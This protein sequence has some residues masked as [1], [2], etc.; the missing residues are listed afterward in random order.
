[1]GDLDEHMK[2]TSYQ[3]RYFAESKTWGAAQAQC[4]SFGGNLA[5]IQNSGDNDRVYWAC[6][7][8]RCWFGL[9]DQVAEGTWRWADQTAAGTYTQWAPGEPNNHVWDTDEYRGM[10]EDCGYLYG[11]SYSPATKRKRWGDHPCNMKLPFVCE[12]PVSFRL[13]PD[14]MD[15]VSAESA[16][17]LAGG[18]LAHIESGV[19]NAN[20]LGACSS[21]RCW[22]G[23]ND[24]GTE[25]QF[26]WTDGSK[27]GTAFRRWAAGEPSNTQYTNDKY[28]G[29]TDEDCVYLHGTGY[30]NT[31]KR[32]K[33]GDHPCAEKHAAVCTVPA[34]YIYRYFAEGKSWPDAEAS[35]KSLNGNLADIKSFGENGRVLTECKTQR[36]WIGANDRYQE[37]D[38]Q[39]TDGTSLG[40]KSS[41]FGKS[42]TAWAR[43]QP[44][45]TMYSDGY[46]EDCAYMH[47][48]GYS[49]ASGKQGYWGDH[50][51][52]EKMP[53]VCQVPISSLVYHDYS[54]TS[55]DSDWQTPWKQESTGFFSKVGGLIGFVLKWAVIAAL[56]STVLF[57]MAQKGM[58]SGEALSDGVRTVQ[59]GAGRAW[60]VVRARLPGAKSTKA[61][62]GHYVLMSTDDPTQD[63]GL[64]PR[65]NSAGGVSA[66]GQHPHANQQQQQ[67]FA[68]PQPQAQ[69]YYPGNQQANMEL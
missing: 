26:E 34:K 60:G 64:L 5:S 4:R 67:G 27:L 61:A 62:Q 40:L 37:G 21:N 53:Y 29:T 30:S 18:H 54:G 6:W 32:G 58:V 28:F 35:C 11:T 48:Q 15:W 56:V 68:P 3:Y 44:D 69:P 65:P 38:W 39:W 19:D 22:I 16:C 42:Y 14:Q 33:W 50:P 12:I 52:R 8:Q 13:I 51:C 66:P 43:G 24:R 23:L 45:N 41:K 31:V 46:D 2:Y 17:V 20:V 47:G 57:F 55:Q 25:G 10:D 49:M 9:N 59:R 7:S 63:E 36:C 1:M